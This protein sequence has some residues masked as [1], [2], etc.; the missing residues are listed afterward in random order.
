MF[1]KGNDTRRRKAA[2]QT[3]YQ[4]AFRLPKWD[5]RLL[6]HYAGIE[7]IWKILETDSFLAR[8]VRFSNDSEEY[9]LG[10][11]IIKEYV[12]EKVLE[13]GLR[14][15][16]FKSIQQGVQ[17]FYMI[18]FCEEGDL[19]S[20]WRGYA[21][22]GVSLGMDFFEEEKGLKHTEM[23]TVL[24]NPENRKD[25]KYKLDGKCIRFIEMPYRVF[26]VNKD[27]EVTDK[28]SEREK[29]WVAME[30]FEDDPDSRNDMLLNLIP[31][32]K[33]LGFYEEAEYR[34]LFSV[35]D[36]GDTEAQ[37]RV[38]MRKKVEYIMRDGQKLPNIAVEMG[39]GEKKEK[40][41]EQ[42]ILGKEIEER[43]KKQG[44]DKAEIDGIYQRIMNRL[45]DIGI[46]CTR[47]IKKQDIYIGEGNNQEDIMSLLE[48]MM[49]EE[50]FSIDWE[51]GIRIWC[52]GHLPIR[53]VIIGPGEKQEKIGESL[54]HF[55]RNT[56]WMRYVNVRYSKIPLQN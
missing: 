40:P 4:E 19:L 49:Q 1:Y 34:I 33:D 39:D 38:I 44:K 9:K 43:A 25:S 55:M 3:K 30:K 41:V 6:Y 14:Q 16:I 56:Y 50:G 5:N 54:K 12:E 48:D 37:N 10:E 36:L 46:S 15:K 51:E 8:N 28:K 24:N 47:F 7:T 23:F 17:M 45:R 42:V 29:F 35:S 27:K 13:P 20:Q 31:F 2:L 52:R 53:E 21:R 22:N 11:K 18:C 32:V 26:Y